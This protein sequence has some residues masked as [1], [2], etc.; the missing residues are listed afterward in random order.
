VN[1]PPNDA[2]RA[3][4]GAK[5]PSRGLESARKITKTSRAISK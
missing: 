1:K 5:T 2:G 4:I 3:E